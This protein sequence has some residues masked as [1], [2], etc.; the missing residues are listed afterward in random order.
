MKP[1][2]LHDP[3]LSGREAAVMKG[4]IVHHIAGKKDFRRETVKSLIPEVGHAGFRGAEEPGGDAVG[5]D[6]VNLLGHLQVKTTQSGFH[7]GHRD[8]QL[9]RRQGSRQR[10]VGIAI[11]HHRRGFF[12]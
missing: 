3:R 2:L 1:Q 9:H 7:M 11:Y 4:Y 5:K 10:G 6:T 8:V 12:R